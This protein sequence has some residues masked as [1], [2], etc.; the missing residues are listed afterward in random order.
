MKAQ[1]DVGDAHV[2]AG[3][4]DGLFL[5][6]FLRH[7]TG[8]A[9]GQDAP[10]AASIAEAFYPSDKRKKG[11]NLMDVE[12]QYGDGKTYTDILGGGPDRQMRRTPTVW[13]VARDH[14]ANLKTELLLR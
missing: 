5:A 6:K 7:R 8:H 2:G 13:S 14:W 3:H 10:H 1:T 4:S 11:L 9:Q 12:R